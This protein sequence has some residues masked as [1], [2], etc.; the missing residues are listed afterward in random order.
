MYNIESNKFSW[1]KSFNDCSLD[2]FTAKHARLEKLNIH[3]CKMIHDC[4]SDYS[5]GGG[6][7]SLPTSLTIKRTV[8]IQLL[9][10]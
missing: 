8:I 9:N 7:A 2:E 3:K 6:D 10:L 1:N 4:L 5:Y